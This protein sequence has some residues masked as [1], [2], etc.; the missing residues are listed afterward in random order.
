MKDIKMRLVAHIRLLVQICTARRSAGCTVESTA[1]LMCS[2]VKNIESTPWTMESRTNA[3]V[4]LLEGSTYTSTQEAYCVSPYLSLLKHL[5]T[6]GVAG[7]FETLPGLQSQESRA[8]AHFLQFSVYDT[9][10]YSVE[11]PKV[12]CLYVSHAG[13]TLQSIN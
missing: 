9:K 12:R 11:I 3:F 13:K 1:Q 4:E 2:C 10:V 8:H 7:S 5:E 6:F